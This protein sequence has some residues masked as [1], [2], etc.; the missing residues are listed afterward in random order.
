MTPLLVPAES[1]R[2]RCAAMGIGYVMPGML[3]ARKAKKRQHRIRL[4]L[5]DALDLLVVSVEAGPRPRSGARRAS[6]Q[7][8]EF[9]YPDLVERAA[10]RQPRAAG[11][12]G[13]IGRAAQ[14]RRPDRRGRSELARRHARADRQVRHERRQ[15]AARVLRHAAHQAAPARGRSRSEDR[16]ED[17]VPARASASSRRSGS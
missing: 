3:L 11:R 12:Q 1:V 17:G 8:L 16:R 6:R 7:E 10:A 5:A 2:R 9:A 4:S 13:P 15:L 14:P